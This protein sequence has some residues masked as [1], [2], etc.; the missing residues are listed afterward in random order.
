MT[1]DADLK[2]FAI[3]VEARNR[4]VLENMATLVHDSIVKG[5]AITGAPGQPVDTGYLAGSWIRVVG[6]VDAEI[7]TDAQYAPVIEHNLR[8]AFD[9][10]GKPAPP[11]V[12]PDGSFRRPIKST[13]GGHHSV[14]LTVG[15]ADR[16]LAEAVRELGD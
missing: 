16:L 5:S 11:R 1:F 8:T 13:V 14:K 3:K 6:S 9:P 7:A 15:A 4:G 10:K 12:N 2:R